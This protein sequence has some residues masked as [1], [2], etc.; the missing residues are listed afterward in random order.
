MTKNQPLEITLLSSE[1]RKLR[2]SDIE[3]DE[4]EESLLKIDD[5]FDKNKGKS[6]IKILEDWIDKINKIGTNKGPSTMN[7]YPSD[8]TGDCKIL[9]IGVATKKFGHGRHKDKPRIGFK[10][11]IKDIICQWLNCQITHNTIIITS[12]WDSD[13]FEKEWKQI[14]DSY[15]SNSSKKVKIYQF[16]DSPVG[17]YLQKYPQA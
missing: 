9:C 2:P 13:A 15:C 4:N 10:G 1:I 5:F 14:I 12:D 8:K 17:S 6:T 3:A 7:F 11:L 16:L